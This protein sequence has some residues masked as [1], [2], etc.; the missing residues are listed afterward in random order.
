[1]DDDDSLSIFAK[2]H[3]SENVL[4]SDNIKANNSKIQLCAH[5]V[6]SLCTRQLASAKY[7]WLMSVSRL[8]SGV[9]TFGPTDGRPWGGCWGVGGE[10]V[11]QLHW[12]TE[13]T[14]GHIWAVGRWEGGR[15]KGRVPFTTERAG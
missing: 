14:S 15:K 6:C 11:E 2:Q 9:G 3:A 1:M 12:V 7:R 4:E 13:Q 10:E 5:V 8:A